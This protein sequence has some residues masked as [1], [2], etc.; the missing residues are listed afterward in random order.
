MGLMYDVATMSASVMR[1]N[2][3]YFRNFNITLSLH[4]LLPAGFWLR[5]LSIP[6]VYTYKDKEYLLKK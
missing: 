6:R 1:D 5:H 2:F 4:E 3:N